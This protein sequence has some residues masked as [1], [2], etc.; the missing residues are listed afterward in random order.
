M[1]PGLDGKLPLVAILRGL[2]P[3]R[4]VDVAEVLVAAGMDI[5][6]VPLNSPDPFRSIGAIVAAVGDR[7]LIGAGTVLQVDQ[8]DRLADLGAGLVVSPNCSPAVIARTTAHGMVSLPG[9]LTPTEMFAALEAGATGLKIF[10]AELVSSAAVK[11]VKAVLP[12]AVPVYVVGGITSDNMADYL[13]AGAAGF[14]M[15]GALFK[16]GKS[17]AA[18]ASDAQKL[19][20]TFKAARAS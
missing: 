18:I 8:V 5:I 4:A 12:P 15:G 20:A 19:V 7:A 3:E 9:V 1:N 14:G 16:P 17:L 13:A 2:E 11:A 6:E 10:P